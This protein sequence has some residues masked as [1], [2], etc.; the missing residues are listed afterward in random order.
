MVETGQNLGRKMLVTSDRFRDCRNHW[1]EPLA[2]RALRHGMGQDSKQRNI[3][4]SLRPID[5]LSDLYASGSS[6]QHLFQAIGHIRLPI[7]E[8]LNK[9]QI[10]LR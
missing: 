4:G 8:Y 9:I 3:V 2:W 7:P 5:T 1:V 10:N 6:S